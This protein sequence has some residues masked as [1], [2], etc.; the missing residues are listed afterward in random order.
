MSVFVRTQSNSVWTTGAYITLVSD[1]IDLDTKITKAINGDKGGCWAPIYPIILDGSGATISGPSLISHQGYLVLAS[2]SGAGVLISD[3][4]WP[5]LAIGH[6]G[7]TRT[8]VTSCLG[9]QAIPQFHWITDLSYAG[10]R[11]IA[12][13][14][15]FAGNSLIQP[16]FVLPV[17]VH[18]GAR[19]TS[20]TI[21][22]RVPVQRK[23]PPVA[24]PKVRL[25]RAGTD[26]TIV[27]MQSIASGADAD[28]Y[29]S[30]PMPKT[31]AEWWSNGEVQ[32]FTYECDQNNTID[33]SLYNYYWQLIEEAGTLDLIPEYKCDGYLVRAQKVNADVKSF[34]EVTPPYP[35]A[36]K[37]VLVFGD[38]ST[39]N[40]YFG[41]KLTEGSSATGA[42]WPFANDA[43]TPTNFTPYFLIATA[44]TLEMWEC[45][46]PVDPTG[47]KAVYIN[48]NDPP[49]L[50]GQ[51]WEMYPRPN[52]QKRNANGN[53]YH[54]VS[55]NFDSIVDMRFQ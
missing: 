14:I 12:C 10:I 8:I 39:A 55:C 34:N 23:V 51:D 20:A 49:D 40:T 6:V 18:N 54:A 1:W 5:Q 42:T 53:I 46:T 44:D 24:T 30:F 48:F 31:G 25:V 22:F 3:T 13:T 35:G 28:G 45:S 16:S 33:T 4:S 41:L 50:A 27:P 9:R 32:S 11:S 52:F 37:R 29:V 43:L 36:N 26:G 15:N 19:L 21:T 17:R 7:R 47:L 2:A 38:G